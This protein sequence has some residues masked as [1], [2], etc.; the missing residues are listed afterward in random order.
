MN[1]KVLW[2][3]LAIGVVLV[4]MPFALSLPSKAAAGERMMDSFQPIMQPDQVATTARYYNDVFVPLGKV[5]PMMSAEN[6]QTFQNYLKGFGGVQTDSAKLVPLLAQSL[7]MTPAQVQATMGKQLPAM[8]AM[9]QNLPQMQ[10]DFGGLLGT[11]Q[12]NVGIF[13][14]VPAGLAHYK[15]LVTTMQA[16]VDNYRQVSSLPDFRLFTVF[17]VVPGVLLIVL[18]GYGLFGEALTRRLT[19]H[20][21]AR[22]TPA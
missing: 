2:A 4:V 17:F 15:P 5:T 12:Q 6:L 18:A 8:S 13:Q 11:M 9:L 22:P 19:F 1:R 16:N 20:H 10:R 21:G 14:Q 3:V 7:H